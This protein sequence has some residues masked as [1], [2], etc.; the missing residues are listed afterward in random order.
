MVYTIDFKELKAVE[1]NKNI[2]Y[3][4]ESKMTSTVGCMTTSE[5]LKW[6]WGNVP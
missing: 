1:T 4:I 3:Y 2:V 6:R 5:T